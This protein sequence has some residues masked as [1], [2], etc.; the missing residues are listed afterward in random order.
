MEEA[1]QL[2][3]LRIARSLAATFKE[4]L[5][6]QEDLKQ[7]GALWRQRKEQAWVALQSEIERDDDGSPERARDKLNAVAYAYQA[8][9]DVDAARKADLHVAKCR[10]EDALR[11]M[12]AKVDGVRQLSLFD[13]QEGGNGDGS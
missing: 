5:G 7:R 13:E 2:R 3:D 9:E 1:E 11:S 4:L 10:V 8:H 6:A 12:K